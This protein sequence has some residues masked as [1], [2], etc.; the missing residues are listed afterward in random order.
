MNWFFGRKNGFRIK[1]YG[2]VGKIIFVDS[3][4]V[5]EMDLEV[6]GVPQFTILICFDALRYWTKPE[7]VLITNE[8]KLEIRS[9]LID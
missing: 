4:K 9:K 8:E 5:C 3:E 6:S 1:S 7:G 2:R